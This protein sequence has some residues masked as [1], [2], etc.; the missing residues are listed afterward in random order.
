[1]PTA[2]SRIIDQ[3][4]QPIERSALAEPQ[5]AR[6]GTLLQRTLEPAL[7]GLSPSR[8]AAALRAADDGDLLS[9]HRLFSDMEGR[10]AHLAAEMGKRKNALV[11]LEWDVLP[12]R[13]ATP[14]EEDSAEWVKEVLQDAID[15]L[16]D[17]ALF[18]M[19]AIGHG[20]AC[21][22]LEWKRQDGEWLPTYH[23]RPQE[24]FHLDWQTRSELRLTDLSADGQALQPFGWAWHVPGKAKTGYMGRMGLYRAAVWPFLYKAYAIGDFAEFLETYGLPIITGKYFNGATAEEKASLLRAVTALGHDARAIMPQEMNLEIA[25]ITSSSDD[26]HLRMVDWADKSISKLIL[27]GTLTSQADGKTSTNALG[28]VHNE[29]RHDILV[30]DAR[31]MAA[32]LTRDLIYPLLALNKGGIESLRRCP[33]LVFDTGE[34]EDIAVLAE[35]LPK[36]VACG[37]KGIPVAWVHEKL[38]IPQADGD[39]A[40]LGMAAPVDLPGKPAP[41]GSPGPEEEG[42][43]VADAEEAT[44]QKETAALSAQPGVVIDPLAESLDHLV[45]AT[46]ALMG[47]LI[48]TIARLIDSAADLPRLQSALLAAYGHLDTERL[49]ELMAAAFALAELKGMSDVLDEA[50]A[51]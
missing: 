19:E 37:M 14:E 11:G 49:V 25:K 23:P 47:D 34:A 8:L 51:L 39:E 5:T 31:Q 33:R 43:D 16:E 17:L 45:T 15:P 41:E 50:G 3:Y 46:E 22:E 9:Q 35:A 6:L 44:D 40:V 21:A 29:V 36:L 12:P 27:G 4:G 2:S 30:S 1:M 10:D 48:G 7:D 28:S 13:N 32:T 26:L 24:W 20:F 38:R 42:E 18:L